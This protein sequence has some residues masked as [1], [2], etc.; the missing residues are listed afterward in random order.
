MKDIFTDTVEQPRKGVS[1]IEA[2]TPTGHN[3]TVAHATAVFHTDKYYVQANEDY[4]TYP[5]C[6]I[7]ICEVKPVKMPKNEASMKYRHIGQENF[8]D[9]YTRNYWRLQKTF[10]SEGEYLLSDY[11]NSYTFMACRD[12]E[13]LEIKIFYDVMTIEVSLSSERK[14]ANYRYTAQRSKSITEEKFKQAYNLT[15]EYLYDAE[16]ALREWTSYWEQIR[17]LVDGDIPVKGIMVNATLYFDEMT[18]A[19]KARKKKIEKQLIETDGTPEERSALRGELKGLDYGLKVIK[20]NRQPAD[21]DRLLFLLY[22]SVLLRLCLQR[23]RGI[24]GLPRCRRRSSR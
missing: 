22:E 17:M 5:W 4:S 19:I 10:I 11:G 1:Y 9:Y 14:P 21:S 16:V 2:Y 7:S 23:T 12:K 15:L 13:Y 8:E 24:L 20:A 6:G 3:S 18:R